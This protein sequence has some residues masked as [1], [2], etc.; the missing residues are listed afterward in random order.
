L[1]QLVLD[2]FLITLLCKLM[3]VTRDIIESNM[4][5]DDSI[6]CPVSLF[7]NPLDLDFYRLKNH[8]MTIVEDAATSLGTKVS[9]KFVSQMSD[10]TCFSFHPRKIITTGEGGMITT[11]K[12]SLEEKIRAFKTF[13]MINGRFVSL[14][15]NYK[16]SDIQSAIGIVQLKKIEKIIK[17]RREKAKFYNELVSKIDFIEPQKNIKN[18]RHTFQSYVC[19]VNKKK[20]R[21]KIIKKLAQNNI[22]SQ[23]GTYSLSCLPYFKKTRK[24]GSLNNSKFLYENSITLPLHAELTKIDQIKICRIIN[25][26]K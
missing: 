3:N 2:Q 22:E 15:T 19:I 5:K 6:V 12:K 17:I 1:D 10:I 7:G 20:I 11:S 21:D 23:I 24:G 16:L 4:K 14:G 13:G 18:S 8:G 26:I 25:S 9:G